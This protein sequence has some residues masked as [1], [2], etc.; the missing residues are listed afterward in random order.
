MQEL[1]KQPENLTARA[2]FVETAVSFIERAENI[3][4]QTKKYQMNLNI[5]IQQ[6]I[7]R[8]N[9]IGSQIAKLNTEICFYES[10]K[11]EHANDLRDERNLQKI[12]H[13]YGIQEHPLEEKHKAALLY[14][15]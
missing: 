6:D 2:S 5:Q 12:K 8:I 10:N 13:E 11:V 4:Q 3:F 9:E 15:Y 1:A 7:G 14:G